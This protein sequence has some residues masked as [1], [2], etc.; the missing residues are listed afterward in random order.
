MLCRPSAAL[1][2]SRS[3]RSIRP[4][5]RIFPMRPVRPLLAMVASLLLS[6]CQQ[7]PSSGSMAAAGLTRPPAAHSSTAS[8]ARVPPYYVRVQPE[9]TG[10]VSVSDDGE[11]TFLEFSILPPG[12][13]KFFDLDGKP[14]RAVWVEN[15]AAIAA[16]HRGILIRLGTATSYV[17]LHPRAEL[18]R[19]P[20][21]LETPI[22]SELRERLLQEGPRAEMARALLRL[23]TTG[24]T[25]PEVQV[26]P[27]G[28]V[29]VTTNPAAAAW[30]AASGTPSGATS[31]M[32]P[33]AQ[34]ATPSAATP[35]QPGAA[36]QTV[37]VGSAAAQTAAHAADVSDAPWPRLQRV[38]FA[39]NSVSISAPDDGLHRLL[40]DARQSDEIWIAGHT[41]SIGPRTANAALARRRAEAIKYI[42]TSR[43]VAPE[44][45]V[46]VRAP[47]DSYIADNETE[48]GRAK[49]RRVEVTFVK[50]GGLPASPRAL[51]GTPAAR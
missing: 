49:N 10:L 39:T 45:I 46:L 40:A 30:P 16:T 36:A 8:A 2:S 22:I 17:S 51:L 13:L 43:G 12:D 18:L 25:T 47:I 35:T 28:H 15:F 14:L 34:S 29:V 24:N 19:K 11:H 37:P 41:D 32:P 31:A 23:N 44:R 48:V 21:V 6:A 7:T 20:D 38:F 4:D 9:A 1:L 5:S 3:I 50:S 42:L 27:T 26:A 33:A